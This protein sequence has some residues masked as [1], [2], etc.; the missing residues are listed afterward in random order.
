MVLEALAWTSPRHCSHLGS[1]PV[2]GS[3]ISA[4][5]L[6]HSAFQIHKPPYTINQC[7][8][9]KINPAVPRN[10]WSPGT[11]SCNPF[12]EETWAQKSAPNTGARNSGEGCAE[13]GAR[14]QMS[15]QNWFCVCFLKPGSTN[16][17]PPC[18]IQGHLGETDLGPT[19]DVRVILTHPHG[20]FSRPWACVC[21]GQASHTSLVVARR[22]PGWRHPHTPPNVG[23]SI[24]PLGF[25]T[26]VW[27]RQALN[28]PTYLQTYTPAS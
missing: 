18:Q 23:P 14:H 6:C 21:L 12:R 9:W 10:L 24:H 19:H 11:V 20:W 16:P 26:G 28:K 13:A 8:L 2:D 25:S 1:E 17:S 4:S 5:P 7:F 3:S 15:T 27:A 22:D